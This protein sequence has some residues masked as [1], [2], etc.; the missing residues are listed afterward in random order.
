MAAPLREFC[1]GCSLT[2][3]VLLI[4]TLHLIQTVIFVALTTATLVLRAEAGPTLSDQEI[5]Q[6]TL[7]AIFGLVALPFIITGIWG[8]LRRVETSVRLYFVFL[9]IS[10]VVD[11][12]FI[13]V[14][15]VKTGFCSKAFIP[16]ALTE[17]G[18]EAFACGATRMFVIVSMVSL[19]LIEAYCLATVWSL[20]EDIKMG[21]S[22][23]GFP[24]LRKNAAMKAQS[25]AT[26]R[27]DLTYFPSFEAYGSLA[28]PTLGG[29]RR[30]FGGTKHVIDFP[31]P[32]E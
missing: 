25:A 6:Q 7:T 30:F 24:Q 16:G 23:T 11:V 26:F 22:G 31:P 21:G 8:A 13:I 5:A 15:G 18:G 4:A 29:S 27:G 19:T 20:A 1:C 28:A 12:I 17:Q 14:V 3:G 2:F 9:A 10:F 32:P